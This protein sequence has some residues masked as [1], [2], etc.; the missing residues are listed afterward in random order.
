[1]NDSV[2]MATRLWTLALPRVSAFV[3]AQVRD[4][5]DRDDI[6]QDT[7][8]AVI[9]SIDR[10]DASQN[11]TAW[12]IGIAR[13]QV[14]LHFRRTTRNRSQLD[15]DSLDSLQSIMA[16]PDFADDQLYV[17][18]RE[19]MEALESRARDM[20]RLRYDE[21]L[22]PA[23]IADRLGMTANHVA[24]SLQRIRDRLRDCMNR[25]AEM[26]SAT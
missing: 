9:E 14:R 22:K 7:A 16:E 17:H 13:N 8:I 2:R 25:K 20:C 5:Q 18:L 6:L 3:G 12:A 4:V 23:A 10:F 21:D 19:C 11:F 24:K 1:M 15:T 26:G